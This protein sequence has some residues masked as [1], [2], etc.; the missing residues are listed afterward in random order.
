MHDDSEIFPQSHFHMHV[1]GLQASNYEPKGTHA[2]STASHIVRVSIIKSKG[3]ERV[4]HSLTT[5][6]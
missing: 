3:K 2:S 5:K 1:S 4:I 6:N